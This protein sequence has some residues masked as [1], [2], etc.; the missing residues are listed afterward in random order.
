MIT[1]KSFPETPC[2]PICAKHAN[3]SL[4]LPNM[5]LE[6][7]VEQMP[8]GNISLDVHQNKFNK[9]TDMKKTFLLTLAALPLMLTSCATPPPPPPQAFHN[10]DNMALVLTSLDDKTCR[11]V[12]PTPTDKIQNDTAL[13][14]AKSFPQHQTAVVILENYSEP[15]VGD[16][17]R[18][19]STSLFVGLRTL[20]YE[21]IVFLQGKGVSNP[22]GLM[23]LAKYD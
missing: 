21:H 10:V 11:L 9:S 13:N 17:F 16:E 19:R 20:G 18:D 14:Q 7:R 5:A 4:I 3:S 15:Q 23:L 8:V 12:Q 2:F 1:G 6:L 22:E